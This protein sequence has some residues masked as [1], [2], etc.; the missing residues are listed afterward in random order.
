[1]AILASKGRD[2][3]R[4]RKGLLLVNLS[5]KDIQ[6]KFLLASEK[7]VLEEKVNDLLVKIASQE[8]Y[9][10]E[11]KKSAEEKLVSRVLAVPMVG[12]IRTEKWQSRLEKL[13]TSQIKIIHGETI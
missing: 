12:E 3:I 9:L 6:Q 10:E 5:G 7:K 11:L 8:N 1:L 4:Y 13:L 2:N